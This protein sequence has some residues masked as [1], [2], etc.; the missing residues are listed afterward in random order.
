MNKKYKKHCNEMNK[1]WMNEHL[2]VTDKTKNDFQMD[3]LPEPYLNF[4]AGENPLY[5]LTTNPG[6][7]MD[8][9]SRD[10]ILKDKSKIGICKDDK[11]EE[12]AEK[13]AKFYLEDLEGAA[14]RRIDGFLEI[15]KNA[16][17]NGV[18]Q[19]ESY[20]FHSKTF[21]KKDNFLG[22][23]KEDELF[24]EYTNLLKE[25][26]VDK[27]VIV[28]SAVG[29]QKSLSKKSID[30]DWLIWQA[31]I[32]G[33]DLKNLKEKVLV[34]KEKKVTSIFIYQKTNNI[35]KGFILMMGGNN[36]PNHDALVKIVNLI[37]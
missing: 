32:M 2:D 29:T 17:F 15:S 33:L 7:G 20:P 12:I 3:Y 27:T 8:D 19:L 5:V 14:K 35:T 4:N 10:V 11:Y 34:E 26:L 16:N 31:D 9:Q 37:N 22:D 23:S 24:K 28:L 18:I 1:K 25:T 21:P 6:N 36:L 13:L 30:T